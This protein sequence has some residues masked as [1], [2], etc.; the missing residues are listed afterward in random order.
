MYAIRSYYEGK[1]LVVDSYFLFRPGA[2][3]RTRPDAF[4]PDRADFD[5]LVGHVFFDVGDVVLPV[6]HDG[7]DERRGGLVV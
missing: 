7:G 4:L 6:V 3:C 5:A 2:A 1:V